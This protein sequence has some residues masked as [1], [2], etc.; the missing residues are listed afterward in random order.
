M[1]EIDIRE[2]ARMAK[3][4][5]RFCLEGFMNQ[6]PRHFAWRFP[7]TTATSCAARW[8]SSAGEKGSSMTKQ[9]M[10]EKIWLWDN[11]CVWVSD[12]LGVVLEGPHISKGH[13][14]CGLRDSNR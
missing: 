8:A 3:F 10:C 6:D 12:D 7:A 14:V 1:N 5:M 11:K 13:P 4:L 9:L 2:V